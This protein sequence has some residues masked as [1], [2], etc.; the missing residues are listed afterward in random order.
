MIKFTPPNPL[1]ADWIA[2]MLK[3][4]YHAPESVVYRPKLNWFGEH[5]W[6]KK[7]PIAVAVTVKSNGEIRVRGQANYQHTPIMIAMVIGIVLIRLLLFITILYCYVK[8]KEAYKEF[9]NEIAAYIQA[10]FSI[11]E[12]GKT[13]RVSW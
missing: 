9:E 11:E 6:V 8:Y 1:T 7:G 5:V 10:D 13:E 12:I 2:E 4:Q 3:N